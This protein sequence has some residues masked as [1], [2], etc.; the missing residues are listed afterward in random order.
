MAAPLPDQAVDAL[1]ASLGDQI[2]EDPLSSGLP[3]L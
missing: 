3:P 1:I 2:S